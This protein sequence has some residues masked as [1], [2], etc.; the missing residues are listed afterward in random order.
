[1]NGTT[2]LLAVSVVMVMALAAAPAQSGGGTQNAGAALSTAVRQLG[3]KV[4]KMGEAPAPSADY[5]TEMQRMGQIPPNLARH[6]ESGYSAVCVSG[7]GPTQLVI[8]LILFDSAADAA[9]RLHAIHRFRQERLRTQGKGW[10]GMKGEIRAGDFQSCPGYYSLLTD[11]SWAEDP[12]PPR[13]EYRYWVQGNVMAEFGALYRLS[14]G[15]YGVDAE[16]AVLQR[17]LAGEGFQCGGGVPPP[18]AGPVV[19][20]LKAEAPGWLTADAALTAAA[21]PSSI[22]VTGTVRGADGS[23]IAGAQVRLPKYGAAATT[24]AQGAYRLAAA[25]RGTAPFAA[26]LD[27]TLRPADT[28]VTVELVV[29]E[30]PLPAPG[31]VAVMVQARAADRRSLEDH[32]V[33]VSLEDADGREARY[34]FVSFGAEGARVAQGR[35]DARGAFSATM[36][37]TRPQDAAYAGLFA[38]RY[39]LKYIPW[40]LRIRAEILPRDPGSTKV[41]G[42]GRQTCPLRLAPLRVLDTL[43]LQAIEDGVLVGRRKTGLRVRLDSEIPFDLLGELPCDV[44][45]FV[46]D[47]TTPAVTG[48]FTLKPF[49]TNPEIDALQNSANLVIPAD[50]VLPGRHVVRLEITPVGGSE[51]NTTV[52][53]LAETE[54]KTPR[55]LKVLFVPSPFYP[56]APGTVRQFGEQAVRFLEQVFP[57]GAVA[58][59]FEDQPLLGPDAAPTLPVGRDPIMLEDAMGTDIL[60]GWYNARHPSDPADF[61]VGVY[62]CGTHKTWGGDKIHGTSWGKNLILEYVLDRAVLN[63]DENTMNVSHEI[64]HCFARGDEYATDWEAFWGDF[65]TGKPIKVGNAFDGRTDTFFNP[66][67]GRWINF[68]G[69]AGANAKEG[70]WVDTATCN[71]LYASLEKFRVMAHRTSPDVR[72]IRGDARAGGQVKGGSAAFGDLLTSGSDSMEILVGSGADTIHRI[73]GS[74][75][76]GARVLSATR[77]EITSGSAIVD[78]GVTVAV[79]GVTFTPR[80]TRYAIH[81]A[82]D[83]GVTV[84]VLRGAVE[85]TAAAGQERLAE[86]Q[87]RRVDPEG[88]I[89][90]ATAEDPAALTRRILGA[91]PA[92]GPAAPGAPAAGGPA[93]RPPRPNTGSSTTPPGEPVDRPPQLDG[94][95]GM[96]S[97]PTPNVGRAAGTSPTD[98]QTPAPRPEPSVALSGRVLA[99]GL[100]EATGVIT[101]GEGP[102]GI[103]GI[104]QGNPERVNARRGRG[105]SFDGRNDWILMDPDPALDVRGALTVMALARVPAAALDGDLYMMVWRGDEQGGKDPYALSIAGSQIV[106]RRDFPRTVQVAWPLADLA[107]DEYHVFCGVHRAEEGTLEL[108]VDGARVAIGPAPK[109]VGYPTGTMRTLVGAM[110]NGK[111]QFFRGVVDEVRLYAR[112]LNADEIAA[113][114]AALLGEPVR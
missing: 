100:D 46:D 10:V 43:L 65:H 57:V 39:D 20:A 54:W 74:P 104:L 107:M 40:Q 97:V 1:M 27:F 111:S 45:A 16:A 34:A 21:L 55:R 14:G 96:P 9:E 73:F 63:C 93:G 11:H 82:D 67:T 76:F 64:G 7:R 69:E 44:K 77:A 79:G 18:P 28:P 36:R 2:R 13:F 86:G 78:G 88:R 42:A 62:P 6:P 110:D 15:V 47:G 32:L 58:A 103:R 83:G 19:L 12:D 29:R 5:W 59:C 72:W 95:A 66:T 68:M 60:L 48:R 61:A 52:H 112:A 84:Q 108:W 33:R 3:Y 98:G 106:F 99:L 25:D 41:L 101:R 4:E 50:A 8:N 71:A 37:I 53:R 109:A 91:A 102:A 80:G 114:A 105:V 23:P 89:Q 35:L 24:D 81:M 75:G 22:T 17:A 94:G 30:C 38:G 85:V 56:A 49:F 90:P 51:V 70:T 92:A 26:R 31:E 87:A 113:E